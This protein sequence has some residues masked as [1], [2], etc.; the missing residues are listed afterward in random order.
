MSDSMPTLPSDEAGSTPLYQ[1]VKDYVR[2]SIL[3]G[4]WPVDHRIPSESELVRLSG[5]SRMTVHRALRELKD[6]GWLR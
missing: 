4:D 5:A 6:D 3:I 2:H 1:Q